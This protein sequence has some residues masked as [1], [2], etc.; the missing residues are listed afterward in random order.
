MRSR[1]PAHGQLT[2]TGANRTY[3][4][5]V[6][7]TGPD[8]FT[9]TANDGQA[10]SP[11]ATVNITVTTAVAP[12]PAADGYKLSAGNLVRGNVLANDTDPD[13]DPLTAAVETGPA[14]GTLDLNP[15]G[16]FTYTPNVGFTGTDTFVYRATDSTGRSATATAT[17]APAGFQDIQADLSQ[18]DNDVD[19]GVNY[20]DGW[21]LHVHNHT[22]DIEYEPDQAFTTSARRHTAA[23][24][25]PFDF[26]GSP[27]RLVLTSCRPS[28]TRKSFTSGSGRRNSPGTSWTA[29]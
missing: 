28:R 3:T 10:D 19:V 4:S 27:R 23:G 14:N 17:I 20:E 16:S 18:L 12:T 21:D 22:A 9:F 8:S 24:R 15:D 7:Y 25:E 6:G 2:G 11:P 1:L 5:A 29:R 13:G 26:L